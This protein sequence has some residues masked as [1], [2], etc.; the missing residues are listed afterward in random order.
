[1]ITCAG[2]WSGL[3]KSLRRSPAGCKIQPTIWMGRASSKASP[4]NRYSV[5]DDMTIS[6][7]IGKPGR[8]LTISV[9]TRG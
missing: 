2:P 9:I 5:V 1:M 6:F 7:P 8:G 4:L 3:S